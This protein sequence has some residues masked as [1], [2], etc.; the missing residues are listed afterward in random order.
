MTENLK[1]SSTQPTEE[2]IILQRLRSLGL[3]ISSEELYM[4]IKN[5]WNGYIIGKY[6]LL[7]ELYRDLNW[8][9]LISTPKAEVSGASVIYK[10]GLELNPEDISVFVALFSTTM[11]IFS[12]FLGLG[13]LITAFAGSLAVTSRIYNNS[14][15][16]A[17]K[18]AARKIELLKNN[19]KEECQ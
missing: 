4:L 19:S 2:Q 16:V 7:Y 10:K 8:R 17:S 15:K 9:M 18:R 12:F 11:S 5:N 14:Q 1:D 6:E 13:D 3:S